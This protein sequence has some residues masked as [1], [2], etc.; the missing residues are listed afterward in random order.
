MSRHLGRR[1][2]D[3]AAVAMG[4]GMGGLLL[5]LRGNGQQL[6]VGPPRLHPV[7]LQLDRVR[8]DVVTACGD[9]PERVLALDVDRLSRREGARGELE[10]PACLPACRP[11]AFMWWTT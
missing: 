9:L 4:M 2:D 10:R 1:R 8:A 7:D 5:P 11:F 6:E 3:V